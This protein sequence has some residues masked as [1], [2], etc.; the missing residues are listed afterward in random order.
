MAQTWTASSAMALTK[1]AQVFCCSVSMCLQNGPTSKWPKPKW[2][3]SKRPHSEMAPTKM[4]QNSGPSGSVFKTASTKTLQT[5]TAHFYSLH[6]SCFSW[7][8]VWTWL[9]SHVCTL[10]KCLNGMGA[11]GPLI[12]GPFRIRVALTCTHILMIKIR[13]SPL[14]G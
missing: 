10:P 6:F 3:N 9:F 8:F 5:E 12:F 2:P 13:Q 7:N 1:M 14:Y 11:M 4:A